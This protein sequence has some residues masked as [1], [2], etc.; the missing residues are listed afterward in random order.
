[1]EPLGQS[2]YE[3][4]LAFKAFV[5]FMH[6]VSA[7][8]T[9]SFQSFTPQQ[10]F[11]NLPLN[12][13][14]ANRATQ[15][16]AKK[17]SMSLEKIQHAADQIQTAWEQ[18]SR[19]A[20][21]GVHFGSGF[22]RTATDAILT[23]SVNRHIK[24]PHLK[25]ALIQMSKTA[26]LGAQ[27]SMLKPGAFTLGMAA[28]I[29]VGGCASNTIKSLA[30]LLGHFYLAKAIIAVCQGNFAAAHS[31]LASVCGTYAGK[32]FAEQIQKL[33]SGVQNLQA[34]CAADSQPKAHTPLSSLA[35]HMR[36]ADVRLSKAIDHYLHPNF[37]LKLIL[38]VDQLARI[39][40]ALSARVA[41]SKE[42]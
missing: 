19:H 6:T 1:L 18:T 5:H 11:S 9:S 8:L 25:N 42:Q 14:P 4:C 13:S 37:L 28:I 3:N 31:L 39:Q 26:G 21:P 40:P 20:K 34:E 35:T 7:Q 32:L 23:Q 15:L 30:R 17:H 38:P 36:H 22:A 29:G 10:P 16:N 27:I 12:N 2:V 33:H 41:L 24:N